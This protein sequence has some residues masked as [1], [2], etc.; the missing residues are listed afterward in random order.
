M[1]RASCYYDQR[2]GDGSDEDRDMIKSA[3]SDL[4][5]ALTIEPKSAKVLY[6]LGLAYYADEGYLKDDS[7]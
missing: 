5:M 7:E 2:N 1:H 6:K 3:I 4:E